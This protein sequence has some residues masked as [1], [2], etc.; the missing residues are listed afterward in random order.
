M[1]RLPAVAGRFYPDDRESLRAAVD[2]FCSCAPEQNRLRA[3][4]CLVPHAGYIYSGAVAGEVYRRLEIP[5]RVILLGPRHFPRG[6]PLA[7]LSDGAWQTPLG[8]AP[9]DHLLAERIVRA[10]PP[11]REDAM[12]HSAEHSLEVQLPFLQRLVPSFAFVPIVLGPA[13]WEALESLGQALA[14]VIAEEREPVLLIAST[15]MNHYESDAITRVKD[16]K[17]IDPILAL[18]ARKLFDTVREEG[19]SMCGCAAAVAA[20]I[21][22]RELGAGEAELV[23]YATSG[24]VNGDMQEVVGYAGM[25]IK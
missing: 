2:S 23:R 5:A 14:A 25:L 11:L 10:F 13:P 15:D 1:I 8:I 22:A 16:R 7:I 3:R 21:A 19:I 17:A 18:D 9:I 12:A 24:E 20:V 4:A 6:A